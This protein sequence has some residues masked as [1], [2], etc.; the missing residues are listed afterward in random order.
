M[1]RIRNGGNSSISI[2]SQREPRETRTGSP[3]RLGEKMG[4]CPFE[5]RGP[6]EAG[7]MTQQRTLFCPS[8]QANAH[9][10]PLDHLVADP[11]SFFILL[12]I[13]PN[14]S[15]PLQ[16]R[17]QITYTPFVN[18]LTVARVTQRARFHAKRCVSRPRSKQ[19]NRLCFL[20]AWYRKRGE[21]ERASR[22]S[23]P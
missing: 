13:P 18:D 22:L 14:T 17:L 10:L 7:Y 4:D 9:L 15:I 20:S 12:F 19:A 11:T 8:K 2:D 21:R 6:S 1:N 5:K 23:M 3:S 16:G